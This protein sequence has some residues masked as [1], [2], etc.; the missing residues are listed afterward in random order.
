MEETN[1]SLGLFLNKPNV[2]NEV[3]DPTY[4]L[5][6]CAI[7]IITIFVNIW[8]IRVLRTTENE[9]LTNLVICECAINIIF[10]I[11]EFFLYSYFWF[12]I[13]N[14]LICAVLTSTA[15]TLL[16]FTRLIPVAIVLIRYLMVCQPAFFINSGRE[17]G[18]LK[19]VIGC[20]VFLCLL[21]WT[22][23]LYSSS[24]NFRVLRCMGREEVFW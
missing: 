24:T 2:V 7:S 15:S 14:Y 12:P 22:Y 18:V 23:R 4:G 21:D 1:N 8:A 9:S 6:N 5:L 10:S 11:N 17:K 13:E 3:L 19:W 16:T 20:M